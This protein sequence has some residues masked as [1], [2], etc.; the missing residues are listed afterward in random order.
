[1][2]RRSRPVSEPDLF[3]VES[4]PPAGA[5]PRQPPAAIMP[6]EVR[7][8]GL[9][10]LGRMITRWSDDEV[11]RL[12]V[13]V[14]AEVRRR[15]LLPPAEASHGEGPAGRLIRQRR[16]NVVVEGVTPAQVSAISAASQ[17][18][19]KLNKIA[20]EFGLPLAAVKRVVAVSTKS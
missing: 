12:R 5:P 8:V 19:I 13:M 20:R 14:T 11:E 9:D 1:M 7:S 16:P 17:A 3:R 18:G 4:S 10:D 15:G 6:D 2:P